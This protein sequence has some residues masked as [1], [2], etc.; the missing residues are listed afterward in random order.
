[1]HVIPGA[2][3]APTAGLHFTDDLLN[4]LKAKGVDIEYVTLH[5]GAGTFSA[6]RVENLSEHHMHSEWFSM[7]EDVAARINEAKA[8]AAASLRWGRPHC[9]R[10]RALRIA[11]VMLRLARAI[12]V[13][14][15]CRATSSASS[16]R[17]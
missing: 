15:S 16:M 4:R 6:V 12:P 11:S 8:Q 14:S 5:V 10:S 1:M 17:S 7:P 9:A 3:A 13:C 2:V